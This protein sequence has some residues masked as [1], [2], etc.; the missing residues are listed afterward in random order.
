MSTA[1][2]AKF[3]CIVHVDEVRMY[4]EVQQYRSSV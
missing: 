3:M 2:T 1:F 4:V